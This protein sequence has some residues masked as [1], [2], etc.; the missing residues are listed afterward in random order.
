MLFLSQFLNSVWT[1][2]NKTVQLPQKALPI[3]GFIALIYNTM[4]AQAEDLASCSGRPREHRKKCDNRES[5]GRCSNIRVSC[6]TA[7]GKRKRTFVKDNT[8]LKSAYLDIRDRLNGNTVSIKINNPEGFIE[9]YAR[10]NLTQ[11]LKRRLRQNHTAGKVQF[12]NEEKDRA[13]FERIMK[14]GRY[15]I[16]LKGYELDSETPA[17]TDVLGQESAGNFVSLSA[18][19]ASS[20]ET[21]AASDSEAPAVSG[22]TGA[23]SAAGSSEE[24][25]PA[26]NCEYDGKPQIITVPSQ[27]CSSKKICIGKVSCTYREAEADPDPPYV[28]CS[29]TGSECP[30]AN[31]CQKEENYNINY[32]VYFSKDQSQEQSGPRL[33]QGSG[34][35]GL[36]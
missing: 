16:S 30:S 14:R 12:I 2:S 4:P 22:E 29:V 34:A 3:L 1:V 5:N 32:A 11:T 9:D 18:S 17:F 10:R 19:A 20:G 7:G 8:P 13:V 28:S 36:R 33:D 35:G 26:L 31:E 27:V 23:G 24:S 21:A 15:S 25:S 6:T